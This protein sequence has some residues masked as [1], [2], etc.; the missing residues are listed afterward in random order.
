MP[1]KSAALKSFRRHG[2]G[3]GRA[4][5]GS[6]RVARGA[7][8]TTGAPALEPAGAAAW[9]HGAAGAGSNREAI[10]SRPLYF[11]NTPAGIV[12]T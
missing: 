3:G 5:A 7:G 12:V 11:S 4:G 6:W 8:K 2:N 1:V 10:L 9:G